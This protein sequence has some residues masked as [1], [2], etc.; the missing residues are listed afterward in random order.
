METSTTPSF[1]SWTFSNNKRGEEKP[2]IQ[3][4]P[5]RTYYDVVFA[6]QHSQELSHIYS[7]STS[8]DFLMALFHKVTLLTVVPL[9]VPLIFENGITA[10][11]T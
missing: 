11:F 7:R 1:S 3:G 9:K 5:I 4:G 10:F 8:K 2:C 6:I